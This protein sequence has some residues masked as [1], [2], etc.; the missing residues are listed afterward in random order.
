MNR[1][2]FISFL[3]GAAGA[4]IVPWRLN[5]SPV[6]FLPS[7]DTNELYT[8]QWS[9]VSLGEG[10]VIS[11]E[12]SAMLHGEG[13]VYLLITDSQGR[14]VRSDF[15]FSVAHENKIWTPEHESS[16][17]SLVLPI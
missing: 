5:S 13:H 4:A 1:R 9:L 3:A 15:G 7:R 17:R 8:Y 6:I 12:S 16:E 10:L 11:R 14:Q 2:G